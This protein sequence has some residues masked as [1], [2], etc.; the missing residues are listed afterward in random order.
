MRRNLVRYTSIKRLGN[1]AGAR[2]FLILNAPN[3]ALAPAVTSQGP[4]AVGG[5]L[6]LSQGFNDGLSGALDFLDVSLPG[7][8]ILRFDVFGFL[9]NAV[10]NPGDF[11]LQNVTDACVSFFVVEDPICTKRNRFL[12]WDS[13]HPTKATHRLLAKEVKDYLRAQPE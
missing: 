3:V 10:A 8:T 4:E 1:A 13:I 12:F 2:N 11:R 9:S 5:A 6:L 7:V